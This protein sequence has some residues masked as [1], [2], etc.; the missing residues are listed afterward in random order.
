MFQLY[1]WG[2]IGISANRKRKG[3]WNKVKYP[4]QSEQT[5]LVMFKENG[6]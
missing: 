2:K 3:P 5:I 6:P 1:L 4:Q